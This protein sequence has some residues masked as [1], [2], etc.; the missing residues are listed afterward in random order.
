MTEGEIFNQFES[1]IFRNDNINFLNTGDLYTEISLAKDI[2]LGIRCSLS[3]RPI[4]RPEDS[5]RLCARVFVFVC[6]SWSVIR[7]NNNFYIY[8]VTAWTSPPCNP[9]R[10]NFMT[11]TRSRAHFTPSLPHINSPGMF[12]IN[13]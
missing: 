5:Y 2:G 6:V 9:H 10:P 1:E 11:D 12:C 7:G 13:A 3:E 8:L 4:P